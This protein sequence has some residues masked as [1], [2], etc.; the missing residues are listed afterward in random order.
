M[1]RTRLPSLATPA[2][3]PER[4]AEPGR[5]SATMREEE[6]LFD[7]NADD[8]TQNLHIVGPAV[9]KDNQVLSDYLAAIPGAAQGSRMLLPVPAG[10]SRP[11]LFTKV[12]K[13][14]FGQSIHRS[15]SAEILEI[16][17]N[18][19]GP[20]VADLVDVYIP[21]YVPATTPARLTISH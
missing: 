17:E 6:D 11:V 21:P 19:L 4:P 5:D 9:S 2:Y 16:M 18:I 12:Q 14:P 10:R 7:S 20:Q 3:A 8:Q 1:G 13:R 15:P